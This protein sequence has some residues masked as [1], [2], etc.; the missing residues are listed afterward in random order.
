MATKL[1]TSRSKSNT[2]EL[3]SERRPRPQSK[4]AEAWRK[5]TQHTQIDTQQEYS[6]EISMRDALARHA[7]SPAAPYHTRHYHKK[8]MAASASIPLGQKLATTRLQIGTYCNL[9]SGIHAYHPH[10]ARPPTHTRP[11]GNEMETHKKNTAHPSSTADAHDMHIHAP[12]P[13]HTST[14]S[15]VSACKLGVFHRTLRNGV[16][17]LR[18]HTTAFS[19]LLGSPLVLCCPAWVNQC[20]HTCLTAQQSK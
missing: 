7:E 6:A 11:K 13:P 18:N 5:D 3:P 4:S 9:L 14:E 12:T 1:P 16:T 2:H 10:L 8:D 20:L 17:A 15:L 19:S